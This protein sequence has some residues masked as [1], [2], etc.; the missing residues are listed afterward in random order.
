MTR[1]NHL[2][3]KNGFMRTLVAANPCGPIAYRQ[4]TPLV[5]IGK[6]RSKKREPTPSIQRALCQTWEMCKE[7]GENCG[8][9]RNFEGYESGK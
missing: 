5:C 7:S 3:G 4:G 8:R 9:R 6:R 2:V 1:R